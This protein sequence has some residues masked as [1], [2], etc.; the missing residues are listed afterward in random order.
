[1]CTH[2]LGA[3][4]LGT[5]SPSLCRYRFGVFSSSKFG[6]AACR[7]PRVTRA[8]AA[9]NAIIFSFK[10]TG[11][12]SKL[13]G[14]TF[15]FEDSSSSPGKRF[16]FFSFFFFSGFV[17]QMLVLMLKHDTRCKTFIT[18]LLN[19]KTSAL[20]SRISSK[21]IRSICKLRGILRSMHLIGTERLSPQLTRAFPVQGQV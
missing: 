15:Q 12:R 1:M 20:R 10:K 8:C 9:C 18:T 14:Y 17:F 19:E 5:A 4:R 6:R 3:T 16:Y 21:L 13:L 11:R 7:V 2:L